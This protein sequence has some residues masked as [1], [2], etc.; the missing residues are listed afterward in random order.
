MKQNVKVV[1]DRKNQ[2][3]KTGTGKIEI[4][5]YLNRDERK[6][7]TVG[8]SDVESWEVAAQ[9]RNILVKVKH[10][11]QI[12]SAMKMLGEDMTIENF[13]KHVFQEIE[14]CS[15]LLNLSGAESNF[16][17]SLFLNDKAVAGQRC[18]HLQPIPLHEA[19]GLD[20]CRRQVTREQ[21]INE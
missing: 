6:W 14:D 8:S 5:V 13:N 9:S 3:A 7:E 16:V 15:S 18:K 4:C 10:Y 19:E 11:E 1:F 12:I 20:L 17:L 21:F 2:A